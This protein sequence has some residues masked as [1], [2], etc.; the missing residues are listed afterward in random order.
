[1]HSDF[2]D[3]AAGL[4]APVAPHEC[5]RQEKSFISA[6][7]EY[8]HKR[9]VE[10]CNF[11]GFQLAENGA[12]RARE[13]SGSLLP[14]T[15]QQEFVEELAHN[16]Y[17]LRRAA[18]LTPQLPTANFEIGLPAID[19]IAAF[20]PSSVAVQRECARYGIVEGVALIGNT[21][22]RASRSDRGFYG[23]VFAGGR[24]SGQHLKSINVELTCAAHMLLERITP[25]LQSS[26]DG[27]NGR[28]TQREHDVLQWLA[29]GLQ[30]KEVAHRL[31]ISMPTV[32]M[33][34]G[35]L[36]RKLGADTLPGA[37]A[38]AMRYGLI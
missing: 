9:G 5:E 25:T 11:G 8:L 38:K 20:N 23:F 12:G 35:N 26:F 27:F 13:F 28:L 36:R 29:E 22:G 10:H 6:F 2:F 17:V 15:F 14:D 34:T 37:V 24:G 1:M 18:E 7:Y 16:D 32:D 19:Q 4:Y 33:H 21:I 30:R 3:F 31:S